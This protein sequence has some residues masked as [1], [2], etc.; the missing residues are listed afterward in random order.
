[1]HPFP[2]KILITTSLDEEKPLPQS[3]QLIRDEVIR[4]GATPIITHNLHDAYEELKRT[5]EISAIFFDWDSE[6]QKC[7]DKLRKFLFPFT[8]QI[9]DHKVLVLPATEKDP[10]LQAKTPLMHLEEEGYTLIVPRSYPDAKISELQKVETHEEL[11]KVMEKDQ[12]KVVPSPLTAIRTFKSINRKILIFLYT[13]RLFIERLPIQ[14][15]ESI[16][17]YFW[18]GEETPTF[19]AKRMVTQASEYIEDILPP[20]FKALVKYLNQGKY[21]WHSPGH[22]GGVAYL[23]SP[24]GKF[25][26]DFYGENMLCSDLSCSVCELGSL[27]NHTG[28]IGE[29]EKYA[30]KVFGSEFTYFVLNGTST[31]NK[32]VFQGTVPSG[33]VV[34]LDRNAHKSSMQAI[35]TGNYKPVYLSPVRNKYGIIGPIPFSEFSVKNVTQKASKMNF[36]N[37]GDIDD[38]VQLFVLTQCTYDG[39]CYNVNK[40]LQS[41]TQL[42]AK[43]AM[44][45]EAWFPYAH[46]HPFYASFHSM[47]K[48]FFDKFDENDE[49]L[50]HGSSALQDTDE[51][52]EVRRSMTPNSFKGTIYA[53]QSTHKVLAAL[54]QCSMVHV[55]NSTDPFKFDKFNTYF[56]ANTTTSPQYSL[57]ASLDMSS[58]IMDI[59]GESILDDV[60]KEVISFR[61]AMARV[62]SEFKES[63]EGW[64]FNVWQPSDILSGKKNI[65]E[66]NYWILPPS[67]PDAWHGFPNIGKNQYLLDPLKV[68][69]LT[70]DEDLDIEIPACVVCRFLAMNG[71]IMEKMGYYTMLSLFTVGSRRGKS[72]TLITA[73]TQ[74]KKLYDTNTPLK[75]VF[76]QE[77]SLDSENVGLK[78]FCNMMNPEIK[79]M[80]EMENATFSG[81]LPEVACSPFVA[82]NALISDEVEWVKV[83]NLTG[84]VSALLCVNYP[85][86]IPT[87]MPGEIFDQLHTDMMIALA[88]FEE[89]WPGYEF[90]VHGLVKKNNNFFIPCLKE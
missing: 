30:S 24:P 51:D 41:L 18:K 54:S 31:A 32:M 37:K 9:F 22:M 8:S 17:A 73:L 5:I 2:I 63:G 56:Q 16:E 58:A 90:E 14:V 83:E 45:D 55:R 75:Y 1:M 3:L 78:D 81:N 89:R 65:Y 49:S 36:F 33:K 23:R 84:R 44:F 13:E 69:I 6:Y 19:V 86:G 7:K 67:G 39:I 85:P 20:F 46:F 87:I 72:A 38:G 48:D 28:P 66:T 42:D 59:S 27:L 71:I 25:F 10:F 40:V 47:N 77:K 15:L 70:V 26:Y 53:T 43:N 12:L 29:A 4:L 80:Q 52:E 21:S 74:F 76:T 82:S 57:I 50:F 60:L 61:C 62:K 79:K 35:M 11:L 64:F 68:N 88:H 34:V